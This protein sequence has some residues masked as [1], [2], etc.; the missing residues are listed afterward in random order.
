[1][2]KVKIE[3]KT[4]AGTL[5]FKYSCVDNTTRKTVVKAVEEGADLRGAYLR[6][7]YLRGAYLRGA[8][9]RGADLRGAYLRGADLTGAYLRGAYLRGAYLRGA[10]LR[11][12]YLRG[13]YLTGADL[14]G[15]YLTGADLTGA[16]LTGDDGEKITI[17]KAVV[18]TG[19]Y[20]YIVMPIIAKDGTQ[21]VKM[22][23][24]VRT[25]KEWNKDFWNNP[26]EFLNHD[27]IESQL[28]VLAYKTAK[29]WIKLN[30]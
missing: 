25:V 29:A 8:Y 26:S 10:D 30:K 12:A 17:E 19:L 6:G 18:I 1:M 23:C 9:L 27:S 15:A 24:Y 11:G 20:K 16:D 22:G 3:I 4:F 2:K 21:Y 14:T 7:A 13:A 28:R 5:L